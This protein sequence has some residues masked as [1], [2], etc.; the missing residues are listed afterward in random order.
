MTSGV[1]FAESVAVNSATPLKARRVALMTETV[2]PRLPSTA[3]DPI[4]NSS[5]AIVSLVAR[6]SPFSAPRLIA[7]IH[8]GSAEVPRVISTVASAMRIPTEM[9]RMT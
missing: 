9:I 8:V 4:R 3:I 6:I 1:P 2:A 5:I 7:R